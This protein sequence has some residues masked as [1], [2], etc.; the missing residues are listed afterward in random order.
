M[1]ANLVKSRSEWAL[2]DTGSSDHVFKTESLFVKETISVI[3]DKS[4][5][6]TLA[7]GGA[8]LAV[9]SRGTAQLLSGTR[10]LFK[11]AKALCVP[12]LSQNLI[13]GGL[14]LRKGMKIIINKEDPNC[15]SLV[16]KNEALFNGVFTPNN[17]MYVTL[18]AVSHFSSHQVN[19]QELELM[20][21]QHRRL[22]HISE[23]YI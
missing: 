15:F 14:M 13:A 2:F 19:T 7:S 8:S 21:L 16:F 22:G 1:A 9:K 12:E 17:L 4:H 3:E 6:L 11:L 20:S 5:C 23:R 18:E 10:R